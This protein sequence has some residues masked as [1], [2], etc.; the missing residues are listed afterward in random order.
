M[1]SC[2]D[3][4]AFTALC[5]FNLVCHLEESEKVRA[6]SSTLVALVAPLPSLEQF[7]LSGMGSPA[8][9]PDLE[10]I[11]IL[12]LLPS[13]VEHATFRLIPLPTTYLLGALADLRC[14]PSLKSL[15]LELQHQTRGT[16]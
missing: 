9:T 8:P 4:S 14:L 5:S 12:R 6:A 3:L 1:P 7:G 16:R 10:A 2:L 11:D 15:S 13:T